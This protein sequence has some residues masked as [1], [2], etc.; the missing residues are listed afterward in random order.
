MFECVSHCCITSFIIFLKCCCC[1]QVVNWQGW[2]REWMISLEWSLILQSSVSRLWMTFFKACQSSTWWNLDKPIRWEWSGVWARL[3][4]F[5]RRQAL[6][7]FLPTDVCRVSLVSWKL[8]LFLNKEETLFTSSVFCFLP[9]YLVP[10]SGY[11]V[12]LFVMPHACML[13]SKSS[14]DF[15]HLSLSHC[16]NSLSETGISGA[17]VK[18]AS[19]AQLSS[20]I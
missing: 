6:A 18:L 15:N 12:I 16:L 13:F 2:S 10:P 14:S 9:L 5:S 20:I 8:R 7:S 3:S 19:N 17:G 11:S 4:V 1:L